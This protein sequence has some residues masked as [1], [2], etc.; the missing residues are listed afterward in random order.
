MTEGLA[1]SEDLGAKTEL[2]R[3]MIG[4]AVTL[5]LTLAA[6][7]TV[8]LDLLGRG[9]TLIVLSLLA[10]AQITAHF[11]YFLHIDLWKS[12]RDDLLLI[13]FASLIILLM[14]GGTIWILFDQWSRM[15]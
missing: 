8:W 6:F 12:H 4:A 9:P 5:V 7:G 1:K 3:Y 14:V 15:M 10:L 11:H 2:R 13:L